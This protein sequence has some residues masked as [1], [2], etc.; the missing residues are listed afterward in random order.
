MQNKTL[1]EI[2][3]FLNHNL[4]T[5]IEIS[6]V[7]EN[8]QSSLPLSADPSSPTDDRFKS[9]CPSARSVELPVRLPLIATAN[10]KQQDSPSLCTEVTCNS[11]FLT[12][13]KN[14]QSLRQSEELTK[15][16]NA[17]SLLFCG[18]VTE[19]KKH[20][21][22][23]KSK[24]QPNI[25]DFDK[26]CSSNNLPHHG[27][28][29]GSNTNDMNLQ[30][31][32]SDLSRIV[33][34][35]LKFSNERRIDFKKLHFTDKMKPEETVYDADMELTASDAG[36]LLTVTVKDKDKSHGN[37]TSN[38]N[39]DKILANFRKVKYSKKVKTKSR[40][41]VSSNLYA[42][43]RNTRADNSEVSETTDSRSQLVQ[44]QTEQLPTGNSVGKQSLPNTS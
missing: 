5:A 14:T 6:S 39:T 9:A 28:S 24:T 42:E 43:K 19:R 33:P 2:E 37:K 8:L 32:S 30:E 35:P 4:L 3:A 25:K 36:E 13:V 38:G 29:S 15:Q 7:S 22:L 17:S 10:A 31:S 23:H 41:E 27:I 26:K 20:A 34:S 40:T 21:V 18:N 11:A 44:S 16:Y 1:R 12:H